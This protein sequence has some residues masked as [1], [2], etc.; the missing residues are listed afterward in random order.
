[1]ATGSGPAALRPLRLPLSRP[2]L[3][4]FG[5]A[6]LADRRQVSNTPAV[7]AGPLQTHRR[8]GRRRAMAWP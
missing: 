4:P 7:A 5:M 2:S 8:A 6:L 1:M 3:A